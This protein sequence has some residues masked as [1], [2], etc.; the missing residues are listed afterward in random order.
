MKSDRVSATSRELRRMGAKVLE[1]HDG[2]LIQGATKLK[3]CEVDGHED[4]AIVAALVVAGLLA[5]GEIKIKNGAA[6][7][8][9]SCSRFI[10]TFQKLGADIKYAV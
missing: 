4:Y 7:L 3:G 6:A 2:L 10:S 8:R 9:T 1:R 5:E